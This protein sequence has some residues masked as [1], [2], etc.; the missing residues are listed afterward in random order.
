MQILLFAIYCVVL[1]IEL[2]KKE[3]THDNT[4]LSKSTM[5]FIVTFCSISP[6]ILQEN[7]LLF[8]CKI[9]CVIYEALLFEQPIFVHFMSIVTGKLTSTNSIWESIA[10]EQRS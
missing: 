6:H 1:S 2:K 9:K 5:F 7:V 3:S 8:I 10:N 4:T